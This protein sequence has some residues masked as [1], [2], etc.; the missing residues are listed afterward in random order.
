MKESQALHRE[1]ILMEVR[2]LL[3]NP[4]DTDVHKAFERAER[5]RR[6]AGMLGL[7]K[8]AEIT[9][10]T[11]EYFYL[12]G[13]RF[14][15]WDEKFYRETEEWIAADF[16]AKQEKLLEDLEGMV[17]SRK[18]NG[19]DLEAR[20]KQD[21][22]VAVWLR[23]ARACRLALTDPR[24]L[25]IVTDI[26]GTRKRMH[27]EGERRHQEYLK[28]QKEFRARQPWWLRWLH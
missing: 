22:W 24:V 2:E 13:E 8:D 17:S 6:K 5:I 3:S 19:P 18:V 16:K 10:L 28:E 23:D 21:L 9:K 1:A 12:V 15:G 20:G 11:H 26:E 4:K 27:E 25:A 14:A 7:G